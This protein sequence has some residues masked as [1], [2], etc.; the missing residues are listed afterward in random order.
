MAT[1]RAENGVA[2]DHGAQYITV[3]NADFKD[4]VDEAIADGSASYWLPSRSGGRSSITRN[5]IVGLPGMSGF[6]RS[7]AN[8]IDIRLSTEVTGIDRMS[9]T[10]R[11]RTHENPNGENFDCVVVT[12]PAPQARTLLVSE[13]DLASVLGSVS[14]DPCLAMMVAFE[15]PLK[16][17][18][19]AQ[20]WDSGD[21]AWIARNSAKPERDSRKDCWVI[22]ASPSWSALH[23]EL[24]RDEIAQKLLCLL[25]STLGV[26]PPPIFHMSGHK[27]RFA[28]TTLPLG[29]PFLASEDNSLFVG[30]DWCLGARVEYAF[31]SGQAIAKAI[32]ASLKN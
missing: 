12:A 2:F 23:L 27:W 1:R 17:D 10:W 3:R 21:L 15:E 16:V 6:V 5:W 20:R 29:K 14:I 19:D 8:E 7:L 13:P 26:G 24:E 22:H 28:L 11:V 30:G 31:E 9:N 25:N 18:F 32:A 4:V